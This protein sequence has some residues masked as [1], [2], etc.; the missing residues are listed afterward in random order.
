MTLLN[1]AAVI[2]WSILHMHQLLL[3]KLSHRWKKKIQNVSFRQL[4]KTW[5]YEVSQQSRHRERGTERGVGVCKAQEI[6]TLG[7][8]I[9]VYTLKTVCTVSQCVP[10]GIPI[11]SF[12]FF[13][14]GLQ[15][16]PYFFEY[17][18]WK[19]FSLTLLFVRLSFN[20]FVCI[21]TPCIPPPA[22]IQSAALLVL[23]NV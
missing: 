15:G 20:L 12:F 2:S 22:P 21:H 1:F 9:C 14:T 13:P 23:R 5:T 4:Y 18:M 3:W 11:R 17:A 10:H 7:F 19:Y 16:V 8:Q 6:C